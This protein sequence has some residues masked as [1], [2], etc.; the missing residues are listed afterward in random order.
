[1]GAAMRV[2]VLLFARA[3]ELAGRD[4]IVV[5]AAEGSTVASLRAAIGEQA[6]AL[7]AFVLRCAVAVG[8]AYALE[9]DAI[10]E[11]AEVAL[12]PPV[13]GG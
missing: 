4:E 3:R 9:G 1:M 7:R 12:I 6:P 8:G 2:R 10:A 11:G 13:S 5:E